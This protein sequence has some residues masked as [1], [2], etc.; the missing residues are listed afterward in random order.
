LIAAMGEP[1]IM[2]R[3]KKIKTQSVDKKL[4]KRTPVN[5]GNSGGGHNPFPSISSLY[6]Y[7]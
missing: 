3:G 5:L 6:L 7:V 4:M 2:R 1:G